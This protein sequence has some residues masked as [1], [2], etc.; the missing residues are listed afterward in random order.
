MKYCF[1]INPRA[2]KGAFVEELEN[3]IVSA[4]TSAGVE[5]DI[6]ISKKLF[7][8]QE[9][10]KMMTKD[11]TDRITFFACGGDG[12]LFGTMLAVMSLDEE[13]RKNVCVGIVPKGTG[14][15]FVSNFD[16]KDLFCDMS[17][18]IEG[19]EHEID[20]LKCNDLYSVNMINIGFDCHVVC[21]KE[22]IGRKKFVPRKLAYIIALVMTLVKKPTV[23][24]LCD[25]EENEPKKKKLLLTTLANG[26]F[27]GGGFRSNPFA[28]LTDGNVDCVEVKNLGR[29][30]F[31][32]M[33]SSYKK[34]KHLRGQYKDRIDH[35]KTKEV[36]L[37]FDG[38]TPVS[39]DGDIIRTKELHISVAERALT[40][41]IPKGVKPIVEGVQHDASY[42]V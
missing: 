28:S 14:N 8:T 41:L 29:I 21:N 10:I 17:A 3:N 16:S 18:Q 11:M 9:Y 40:I 32:T 31:L 27:C 2:G 24:I 37:C 12:T 38:E 7:N 19:K 39:V 15:D 26:S 6:F 33:V 22:K 30:R 25:G 1:I 23:T 5:Y 13:I 20:L 34:G 4:C 35:F 36:N 42:S